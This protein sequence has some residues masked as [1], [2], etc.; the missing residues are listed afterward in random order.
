MGKVLILG[1]GATQVPLIETSKRMGYETIVASIP[2]NYPGFDL[3]DKVY[4]VN[5]TDKE[6]ILSV[7]KKEKIDGLCTTGTDVAVRSIGY[8]N[9]ALGLQ[10][11]TYESAKVVTDKALMKARMVEFGVR[12]ARFYQARTPDEALRYAEDIGFPVMVKCTDQAASKGIIKVECRDMISDAF[13]YAISGSKNDYV[14]VE[15]FLEGYEAGVDGYYSEASEL[16]IPHGKMTYSTGKT[17]VP[18]GHYIPFDC[19]DDLY[20]DILEQ[21]RLACKACGLKKSFFNMDIMICDG[22]CYVIEIG[23]RTGAT[24]IPDL[25]S[26]YCGFNYYEKI[27]EN[28]VGQTPDVEYTPQKCGIAELLV[29]DSDGFLESANLEECNKISGISCSLDISVGEAV[30]RFSVGTDR[31]GQIIS[32]GAT[33]EE[34]KDKLRDALDTLDIKI[35]SS[36]DFVSVEKLC[37]GDYARLVEYLKSIDSI[38]PV[39]MSERVVIDNHAKKVLDLGAVFVAS[40]QGKIVGVLLGYANNYEKNMAYVGT[41]GVTNGFRNMNIGKRLL[42][43]FVGYARKRGMKT[44]SLHAHRDNHGA[45][46][47]YEREGFEKTFD[48]KKPYEESVYFTMNL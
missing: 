40:I 2:G 22:K 25:L 37:E 24:C 14:V 43:E 7:A 3:A 18:S 30:K 1:A 6:G 8:V 45:L 9:S 13:S 23:G 47:F 32:S 36:E 33:A 4:H 20:S 38:F 21:T 12:T 31:F 34:A 35:A 11:I 46:R 28:C 10:G 26:I 27:I 48:D 5:T 41:L 29:S 15:K 42:H 19:S 16:I 17:D 39:P 44:V